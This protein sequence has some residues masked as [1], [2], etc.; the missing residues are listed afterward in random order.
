MLTRKGQVWLHNME[1]ARLSAR[2]PRCGGMLLGGHPRACAATSTV[3]GSTICWGCRLKE[4]APL[5][6]NVLTMADYIATLRRE[7]GT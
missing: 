6:P 1:R 4:P 7:V 5:P 3:D 2:C